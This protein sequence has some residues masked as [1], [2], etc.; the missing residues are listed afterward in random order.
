MITGIT[1]SKTLAKHIP[2]ERKCKFDGKKVIQIF[3]GMTC[4]TQNFYILFA[5]L[6]ITISL[7]IAV[8]IYYYLLFTI[9]DHN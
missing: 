4:N 1:E 8:I 3:G 5:L 9:L 7:L 2:C 6:L